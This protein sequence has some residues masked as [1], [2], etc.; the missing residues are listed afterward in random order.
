VLLYGTVFLLI[1][2]YVLER[3]SFGT[4]VLNSALAQIHREL[5]EAGQVLGIPL[6][7]RIARILLPLL[8]PAL[9]HAWLW[10][11]L[12]T[13]RE[14]TIASLLVTPANVTLPMVIWGIW[15]T[16]SLSRA[17]AA[18]MMGLIFMLPVIFIYL[19]FGRRIAIAGWQT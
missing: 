2:I 4:R 11:A 13:Y 12:L 16:G 5:E 19:F 1:A 15:Q 17:A 6:L 18:A 9:I 14:L 7:R 8:L 10:I 3:I